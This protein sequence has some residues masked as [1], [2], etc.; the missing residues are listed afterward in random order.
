MKKIIMLF[1]IGFI[2]NTLTT[3][4]Q[5][6]YEK[7]AGL[8]VI[9]PSNVWTCIEKARQYYNAGNIE[10]ADQYLRK[11]EQLTIAAEPFNPKNWP[12]HWPRTQEALDIIR[13]APPSA[14]IYRI[15]AD[16][17]IDQNRS[18][19]AVK[20]I[21]LYLNRSY[22]PDASYLYKLGNLLE[23]DSMVVQAISVYQELINCIK[24][25]NFH[26]D[27]PQLNTIERKI[28]ILNAQIEPVVILPLDMKIQGLPSFLSDIG[29]IFKE[30]LALLDGRKYIV[31]KDQVLDKLLA[32]Q[33]L[34]R[35]EIIDDF[36]ER[37]RII[38]LLNVNYVLEPAIAKIENMY[39]FQVRVYRSTQREPVET[40]EY[41]NEN[42]EFLPN[43]LQRFVFE[44]QDKQ[45][46]D[47]LL[48]PEN[49]YQW[50]YEASDNIQQVAMSNT[51]NTII[52]GCKDG[53]VYV[54]SRKGS[55]LGAFKENDEII[56]VAV[57]PDGHYTSWASIDGKITLA[58]AIKVVFRTS[59]KNLVRAISIGENGKFWV[60]AINE[61]I[62]YLDNKGEIYW[63]RSLP[64]W[65][66]A[67]EISPDCTRV[68]AGSTNG[69]F[70]VYTDEGNLA[71]SKKLGSPITRISF[72]P[73]M[74]YIA[75]GLKNNVVY[76][77]SI[78]G[79]E[80]IKFTLGDEVRL[81]TFNQDLLDSVVGIWNLWY[82]FLDK[83]RS[84][85]WFYS[86]DK[87]INCAHS[88][89]VSNIYALAKGKSLL[90]YTVVWK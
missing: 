76:V 65:V 84:K 89:T 14:Y 13:Y 17:A 82:Y 54:F 41:K 49:S 69:D 83:S 90:V 87:S 61:K 63:T 86:V 35:Q 43:Y 31:I 26:N 57:S 11:A 1:A 28:R 88:A 74:G 81:L 85:V 44:F 23:S 27:A 80:V 58:D 79:D 60:Y 5:S 32:E 46:P 39:I 55:V 4:A 18:K 37:E 47:N 66:N 40:F 22:I 6:W 50:A 2:L 45:I 12:S 10:L 25:R 68:A 19:E 78:N 16:F 70:V 77:F 15:F 8:K 7:N 34:T 62:Y 52:A 20:Y 67:M 9:Y 21:K 73:K 51:G 71:W 75:V 29:N 38:K 59:S 56:S 72:S 42:Y 36:E 24:T 48:I 3:F 30:K 64:D 33:N 53:R